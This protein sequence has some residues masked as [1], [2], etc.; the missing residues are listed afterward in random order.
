[1]QQALDEAWKY[2]AVTYPN[3]P[4]G[5]VIVDEKDS[6]VALGAHY[7]AGFAHAEL[8]CVKNALLYYGKSDIK[9]IKDPNKLHLYILKNYKNI[10]KDHTIYVTLEPCTHQGRTPSCS[11]LLKEMGFSRVVISSHDIDPNASGGYEFLLK[12]TK[13]DIGILSEKSD[14]LLSIFK[15]TQ[16][17][18]KFVFFK[19]A[20]SKNG[21]YTGGIISSQTSRE[22]VH[23]LRQKIDLLVIGGKSVRVDRPTLDTRLI[24]GTNPPDILIYSKRDDFDKT[25]PL[26]GIKNRKVFISDSLKI[27][28]NYKFIMIEGGENLFKAVKSSCDMFMIFKSDKIQD[29]NS[30]RFEKS[31]K[32]LNSFKYFDDTIEWYVKEDDG[33]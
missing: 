4:V 25:I 32:R 18:K 2:Q 28:E 19:V 21:V 1:M 31:L 22:L 5:A 24:D 3:P 14:K 12:N 10:F 15:A 6:F 20:V 33:T 16:K 9:D 26:F 7:E 23:N 17:N 29:G 27:V 8:E 30:F 11:Q 13:V